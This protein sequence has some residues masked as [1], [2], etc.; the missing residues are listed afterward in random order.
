MISLEPSGETLGATV[1]DIDLAQPPGDADFG[2]ILLALG[3][4]GVLHFANQRLEATALRLCPTF[5]LHPG[6]GD[7]PVHR[8]WR[9]RGGDPL[10]C[11]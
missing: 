11:R 3:Q 9:A 6:V 8:A 7:W 10:Q 1:H 2:A 5:R 4:Y